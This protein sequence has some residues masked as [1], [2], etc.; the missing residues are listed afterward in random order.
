MTGRRAGR[1]GAEIGMRHP[2]ERSASRAHGC[3]CAEISYGD[4]E[5]RVAL[6]WQTWSTAAERMDE[7]M[8]AILR[9]SRGEKHSQHRA[10]VRQLCLLA[11]T[12]VP[13]NS[14]KDVSLKLPETAMSSAASPAYARSARSGYSTS[15][16]WG[17][18]MPKSSTNQRATR[19]CSR[20]RQR[21]S[22]SSQ[23]AQALM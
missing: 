20:K 16:P 2:T 15:S 22:I 18:W 21:S 7:C 17:S 13:T 5:P 19:S 23:L 10:D 1:P 14:K 9:S 8:A 4:P 3:L 6:A 12:I 11:E